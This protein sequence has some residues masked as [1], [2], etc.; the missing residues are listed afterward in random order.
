MIVHGL[1]PGAGR[2]AAVIVIGAGPAGIVQA[3]ELRRRG[4]PVTMLAGGTD[5]YNPKF[6]SLADAEIADP[7]RHAPMDMAVRRALGGT[8]L[9]W[10]GRVVAFDD[11]DFA[12]RRHLPEAAWPLGHS[13]IRPWY[14]AAGAYLDAGEPTFSAPF[15]P[16]GP[17]DECR[18]DRLER[19]SDRC[20][21]RRLHAAALTGDTGLCICLGVVATGFD[22]DPVTGHVA[23]VAVA[24][25]DGSRAILAARAIVLAC[26]G[27]E[28]TRLLLTVQM[29]HPASFGGAGGPLGRYYMGHLEGRIAEIAFAWPELDRA[30]DFFV[31][32]SGR[33]VRRRITVAD[34]VQQ[35]DG[36]LNLAAWPDNPALSNPTHGSAILSLAYLSLAIPGLGG[37]LAPEA[38]RRKHLDGSAR[39]VAAHLR[40][41]LCG[42]PRAAAAAARFLRHRYV[43]KPRLPGFFVANAARRYALFYH[44]EQAPNRDSRVRLAASHDALGIPRLCVDLR[45]SE[46]DAI[47]VVATHRIIDRHLRQTGIGRL[48]Y[49]VPEENRIAAVLDQA[50]DGYHQIGTTRMAA[51]PARG[52]V[53]ADCRVHGTPNLFIASSSIF[54][55]S[56]QA[57]PTLLLCAFSAR[58]ADHL[59]R[60]VSR[61]PE[62]SRVK[63]GKSPPPRLC[64]EAATA[65]ADASAAGA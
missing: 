49:V 33:Y 52:V 12:P 34:H 54:P 28:T 39:E 1:P 44:A 8:S 26:G 51:V 2:D 61:L 35:R 45:Y 56:G 6:Q 4:V 53:D 46:C 18:L 10:G 32:A 42:A 25:P 37:L 5:G 63:A 40:N 58:L 3:L 41:L 20:N 48:D 16:Q 19:W 59:A 17:A 31:D 47:S 62:A 55:S 36:L 22:I 23:G 11:V 30:L 50:A 15:L 14:K 7:R 38:V 60:H 64:T 27:L 24:L 13:E 29:T 57:N 21:L 43:S 9:L 65:A